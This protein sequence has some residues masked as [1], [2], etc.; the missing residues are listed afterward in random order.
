MAAVRPF[1]G[2]RSER[3]LRDC[4]PRPTQL[5]FRVFLAGSGPPG[6]GKA[7]FYLDERC[8]PDQ[9]DALARILTGQEG[10]AL[11]EEYARTLDYFPTPRK[12]KMVFQATKLRSRATIEG[13]GAVGL[14]PMRNPVTGKI[15]RAAIEWPPGREAARTEVSSS[16]AMDVNY[17]YP[18]FRCTGTYGRFSQTRWHGP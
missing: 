3:K 6:P 11:F 1:R 17:G 15:H 8:S 2:S 16:K 9:F 18:G 5:R 4:N 13:V 10:G 14:E 7:A 12:A